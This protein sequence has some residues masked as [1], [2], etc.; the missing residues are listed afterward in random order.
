LLCGLG[1]NLHKRGG[2]VLCTSVTVAFVLGAV[3]HFAFTNYLLSTKEEE[4]EEEGK[5]AER[6]AEE[7][8]MVGRGNE[9]H[10]T[11]T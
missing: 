5:R 4:K 8:I 11:K 3:S 9:V 1:M 6:T 7:I 2:A 10:C